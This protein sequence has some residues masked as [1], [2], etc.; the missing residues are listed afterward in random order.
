M[1][2]SCPAFVLDGSR[3]RSVSSA[4]LRRA[5]A[6]SKVSHRRRYTP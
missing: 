2:S 1:N 5:I 3:A 6:P 4:Q